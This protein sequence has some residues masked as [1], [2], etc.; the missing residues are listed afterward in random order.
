MSQVKK[1]EY[2]MEKKK[3]Y[4][5]DDY[6]KI[7]KHF[8]ELVIEFMNELCTICVEKK[9]RKEV[10]E[11]KSYICTIEVAINA[12]KFIVAQTFGRSVYLYSNF[13]KLKDENVL[14]SAN[15]ST[16]VMND[17]TSMMSI[18]NYK[19]LWSES[20]ELNKEYIFQTLIHLC[21]VF[22]HYEEVAFSIKVIHNNIKPYAL[23]I[24]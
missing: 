9:W 2:K 14:L 24:Q 5:F 3:S 16:M 23:P 17:S 21:N 22:E 12:N 4:V 13:I 20:G 7:T 18:L 10:D 8:N 11:I 19:K 6:V 1:T 15:Y